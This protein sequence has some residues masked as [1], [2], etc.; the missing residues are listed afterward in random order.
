VRERERARGV[1][2]RASR[3]TLTHAAGASTQTHSRTHTCHKPLAHAHERTCTRTHAHERT[4]TRAR[5][6]T[7]TCVCLCIMF[8][9]QIREGVWG[10][11]CGREDPQTQTH[12]HTDRH[13]DGGIDVLLE[14]GPTDTRHT[15]T[16]THRGRRRQKE[17]PIHRNTVNCVCA[18]AC[19]ASLYVCVCVCENPKS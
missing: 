15:D 12:R 2:E 16:Q 14:G 19:V 1:S 8:V 3:R 18:R 17:T 4:C 7:P 10:L 5:I 11:C 9:G 13:T 6:H